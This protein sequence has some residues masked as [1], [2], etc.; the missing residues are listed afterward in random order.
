[1]K[2]NL[3]ILFS[4][5][6]E[7]GRRIVKS[8][9]LRS[10][11]LRKT[12]SMITTLNIPKSIFKCN[13]QALLY[14]L[15]TLATLH[16]FLL[17]RSQFLQRFTLRPQFRNPA[18][19]RPKFIQCSLNLFL[20]LTHSAGTTSIINLHLSNLALYVHRQPINILSSMTT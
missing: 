4:H 11:N 13:F 3:Q 19:Q 20:T 8:P 18:F 16:A 9:I 5:P 10:P 1:M 6:E 14:Q 12:I 7:T 17:L 15:A 2:P